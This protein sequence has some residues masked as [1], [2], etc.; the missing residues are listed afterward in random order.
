MKIHQLIGDVSIAI[1]NEEQHFIKSHHNHISL[2]SL[3]ERETWIAQNL[4][5]K[6]VYKL[7]NNDNHIIINKGHET[8]TKI[9]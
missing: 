2:S 1:T 4:V 6:H 7:S 5:R 9:L 3:D 8:R